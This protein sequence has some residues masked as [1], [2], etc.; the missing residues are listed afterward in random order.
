[1][2]LSPHH[3][4]SAVFLNELKDIST[5]YSASR[6]QNTRTCNAKRQTSRE[7]ESS[8]S[9]ILLKN[10]FLR[11]NHEKRDL[12]QYWYSKMTIDTLCDAVRESALISGGNRV[13]FLSTPSLFFSLSREERES[14]ALFDFDTS[15]G[16]CSGYYHYDYNDPENIQESCRGQFDLVVI[17]PPFISQCVWKQYAITTKLLLKGNASH[18]MTTTVD[19]NAVL[20]AALFDCKP[21]LFRPSIPHLVYQYSVFVN[22][23]SSALAQKNPEL[24]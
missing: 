15:W 2:S 1:M 12:N 4:D 13:A 22:F 6:N 23:P 20:M 7:S 9:G 19:E 5:T 16:T 10:E 21:T 24:K 14:C 18:V 3:E 17:D 11:Q 8:V